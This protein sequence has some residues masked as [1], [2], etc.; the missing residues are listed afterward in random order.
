MKS[1]NAQG[2]DTITARANQHHGE[3]IPDTGHPGE[4]AALRYGV[5]AHGEEVEVEPT[6]TVKLF[7]LKKYTC[8]A[9][10]AKASAHW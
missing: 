8:W 3:P 1:A 10:G 7:N 5:E 6:K 2:E 9:T 4:G